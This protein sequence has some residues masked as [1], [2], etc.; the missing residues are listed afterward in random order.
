MV[1]QRSGADGVLVLPQYLIQIA[2]QG[3]EDH[4]GAICKAIDIGVIAYNRDNAIYSADTIGRV[5]R[6]NRALDCAVAT[7]NNRR[8]GSTTII[9]F[10]GVFAGARYS[11][12]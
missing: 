3:L 11:T 2:Q 10:P 8:P 9:D 6:S 7:M 5:T 4:L 12:R 1:A